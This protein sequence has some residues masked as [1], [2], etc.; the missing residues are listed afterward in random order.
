MIDRLIGLLAPHICCSCGQENALLC[1]N[2]YFDIIDEPFSQ[3]IVCVQPTVGSNLCRVCRTNTDIEDAWVVGARTDA[4]K[5]LI[6]LYKFERVHEGSQVAGRLLDARIPQLSE[7]T[8]VCYIPDIPSH[9][10]QRGYDHV[11]RIAESFASRRGMTVT[12]LLS[13]KTYH[14]QRGLTRDQRMKRQQDA[15]VV[16]QANVKQ[17]LLIDDIYT[18]GATLRA[19]VDA[20]HRAGVERVYVGIIARQPLDDHTDL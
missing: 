16:R 13:R 11:R 2:C 8:I 12:S 1:E 4:L 7:D 18:T 9:R 14:S 5:E 15:F 6:D 17:C 3:C 19:G 20:L 10:R